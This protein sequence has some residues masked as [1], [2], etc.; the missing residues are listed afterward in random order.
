MPSI[1]VAGTDT[2]VGKTWVTAHLASYLFNNIT[3]SVIT[4]KWIQTG[5]EAFS[6]DIAIHWACMNVPKDHAVLYKKAIV[7]YSFKL[8]A[9]PHLAAEVEGVNINIDR[10]L[11][12]YAALQK[13]FEW[14][15]VEGSG[16]IMTPYSRKGTFCDILERIKIPVLLV[17]E[18][19]VGAI[20][21]VLTNVEVL[22]QRRVPILGVYLNQI[23]PADAQIVLDNAEVIRQFANLPVFTEP[24]WQR[25]LALFKEKFG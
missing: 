5:S 14:V 6:D 22:K 21:Q 4:Q 9:S 8:P 15:I 20:N 7:P 12:A 18:N 23:K 13:K 10:I 19:R 3:A 1:F 24:S 2:N 17:A 16:G 25:V 11:T